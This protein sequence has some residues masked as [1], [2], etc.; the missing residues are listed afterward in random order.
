MRLYQK[1]SLGF[2]GSFILLG[3]LGSFF[4]HSNFQINNKNKQVFERARVETKTVAELS[5]SLYLI[6][7]Y[8]RELIFLEQQKSSKEEKE[9]YRQ[10]IDNEL[11]NLDLNVVKGLK[12]TLLETKQN[13]LD[14][15]KD[16]EAQAEDLGTIQQIDREMVQYKQN[17][18]RF[19]DILSA[20]KVEEAENIYNKD[21]SDRF[22]NTLVPLLQDYND[23]SLEDIKLA[24][25]AIN[26]QNE[27]DLTA[28]KSYLI[29]SL[30]VSLSLFLYIYY[31]IYSPLRKIEDNITWQQA[32]GTLDKQINLQTVS[33]NELTK[34]IDVFN[35]LIHQLQQVKSSNFYLENTI[36]SMGYSSI[37]INYNKEIERVNQTTLDILGYEKGELIGQKIH[38]ILERNAK[39]D[40]KKLLDSEGETIYKTKDNKKIL[41]TLKCATLDDR[42][43]DRDSIIFIARNI[44]QQ[45]EIK[46]ALRESEERYRLAAINI[47]DGLWEWNLKT[48]KVNYSP[49]W[50][51]MLGYE[52]GEIGNTLKEWFDRVGSDGKELLKQKFVAHLKGKTAQLE[53]TYPIKH[54]NGNYLTVLCR[55][56]AVR[57]PNGK[58]S[59]IIGTQTDLTPRKKIEEKLRYESTHDRLTKLPNRQLLL[60]QLKQLLDRSNEA[61]D[62]Y[63]FGIIVLDLDRFKLINDSL[64]WEASK[65]LLIDVAGRLSAYF[66]RENIIARLEGDRFAIVNKNLKDL[67]EIIAIAEAIQT[68]LKQPFEVSQH[69]IYLTSSIGIAICQ[70]KNSSCEQLL[71]D[72]ETA[73]AKAKVDPKHSLAVFDPQM[74]RIALNRLK[75]ETDLHRAIANGEFELYYQPI[76]EL[77]SN[78]IIGFEALTRWQHPTKGIIDSTEYMSVARDIGVILP[79]ISK[80]ASV[81]CQQMHQWQ[82]QYITCSNLFI[83]VNVSNFQVVDEDFT[84]AIDRILNETGLIPQNLKLKFTENTIGDDIETARSRLEQLKALGIKVL[85]SDFGRGCS[86]LALLHGL[87]VDSLELDRASIEEIEQNPFKSEI[88]DTTINLASTAGFK[89]FAE[90]IENVKQANFL[91]ERNCQYG[92]GAFFCGAVTNEVAEALISTQN[93]SPD[94][95]QDPSEAKQ[96]TTDTFPQLY[97]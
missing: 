58:I 22:Q 18:A 33:E 41:V 21:L 11:K 82:Q 13:I 87:P 54:K 75:L 2:F 59:R 83:A 4:L 12:A 20:G 65:R 37:V 15:R 17:L 38:K 8:A 29:F 85:M 32:K 43:N 3:G 94:D 25:R 90:G 10:K 70:D 5:K 92:Q 7:S 53:I 95:S 52:A 56:S 68:Q 50:Q 19:I 48:K 34:L 72:A 97:N 49:R 91:L 76:V 35:S 57:D 64:G 51:S 28:V 73:T 24:E 77:A 16:F 67:Q 39:I 96:K 27:K 1:I 60:E 88:I 93:N 45:P 14:N 61:K 89:I 42:N 23:N 6:Q 86:S 80:I 31:S 44:N 78:K 84:A 66:G 55:A 26:E 63:I 36:D 47:N 46:K 79:L 40:I 81:A 9:K 69:Q 30:L 74:N 71:T 62:N